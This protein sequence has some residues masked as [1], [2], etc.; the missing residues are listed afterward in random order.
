VSLLVRRTWGRAKYSLELKLHLQ[1]WRAYYHFT[2]YHTSLRVEY[3][4]PIMRK[5]KQIACRYRSRTPA[6]AAG[7]AVQRWSVIELI[8]IQVV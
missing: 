8:S 5:G 7:L 4:Q 1:W 2:R 3:A 6:M